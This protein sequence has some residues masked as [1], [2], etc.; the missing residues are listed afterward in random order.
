MN[1]IEIKSL[2]KWDKTVMF[3]TQA[4]LM[5]G[6]GYFFFNDALERTGQKGVDALSAATPVDTGKTASSWSYEIVRG[7]GTAT[8]KW[9]NSDVEGGCNV[10]MLIQYGHGTRGGTYVEGIDYINPALQPVF[11]EMADEV[12]KEVTGK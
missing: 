12:W 4:S 8:I 3:L 9:L 7:D 10:A 11:D 5:A 1:P 6:V 2:G